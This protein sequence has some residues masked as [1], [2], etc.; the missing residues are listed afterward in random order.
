MRCRLFTVAA[1]APQAGDVEA[2]IDGYE[3]SSNACE[4]AFRNRLDCTNGIACGDENAVC[5]DALSAEDFYCGDDP[6]VP[7]Y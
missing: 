4:Q 7:P 2:C 3:D 1:G 5:G 6:I